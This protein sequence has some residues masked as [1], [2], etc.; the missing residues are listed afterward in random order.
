MRNAFRILSTAVVMIIA[1]GAIAAQSGGTFTITK[2]VIAGGGGR[3]AGGT[4]TVDG[5][6]GESVAGTTSTGSTFSLTS[7]FWGGGTAANPVH[8]AFFDFDGDGK[9]DASIFRPNGATGSEWWYLK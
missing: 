7:G 1:F 5:T 9:T 8:R 2:S 4:F 3:T 6:I